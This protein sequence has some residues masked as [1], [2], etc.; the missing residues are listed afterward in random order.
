[1]P[2]NVESSRYRASKPEIQSEGSVTEDSD[3]WQEI[4]QFQL[5]RPGWSCCIRSWILTQIQSRFEERP[6]LSIWWQEKRPFPFRARRISKLMS[7]SLFA[8]SQISI[9]DI[10]GSEYAISRVWNHKT[11]FKFHG[12]FLSLCSV[13]CNEQL[14]QNPELTR[15]FAGPDSLRGRGKWCPSFVISIAN[16]DTWLIL[17]HKRSPDIGSSSVLPW[18]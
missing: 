9:S 13:P 11:Q 12:L 1:M 15:I 8:R 18:I 16:C 14:T 3:D 2:R 7:I 6:V 5:L 10:S 17:C 4:E